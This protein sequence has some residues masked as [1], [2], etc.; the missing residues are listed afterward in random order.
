[1][2]GVSGLFSG[3]RASG[4]ALT[5]ERIHIDT[6]AQN[7]ANANVTQQPDGSGPYRRQVVHFAPILQRTA[8]GRYQSVG[9]RVIKV[10]D[11]A[12][13]PFERVRDP[14]HP[15]AD[16]EG[17]VTMPNVNTTREMTD[18]IVAMRAYEANLNAQDNF[19]RMAERSLRMAQ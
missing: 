19:V 11:D 2:E 15:D 4:S 16:S 12:K 18:M 6:I 14:G 9:V 10:A 3:M 8:S 5:A 13:S 1:M 7:L 17:M